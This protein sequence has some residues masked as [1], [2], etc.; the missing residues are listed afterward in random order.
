[1]FNSVDFL[2]VSTDSNTPNQF[3][4]I[5]RISKLMPSFEY[6]RAIS[7]TVPTHGEAL[8]SGYVFTFLFCFILNCLKTMIPG[9]ECPREEFDGFSDE[10]RIESE[11]SASIANVST[12]LSLNTLVSDVGRESHLALISNF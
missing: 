5:K 11:A 4:L 8:S 10:D 6:R 2:V 12:N 9:D 1:M 7:Q 3:S